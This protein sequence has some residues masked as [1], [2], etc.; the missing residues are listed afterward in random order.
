MVP[1][2]LL[3]FIA[4]KVISVRF[5]KPVGNMPLKAFSYNPTR[6]SE[7]SNPNSVGILPVNSFLETSNKVSVVRRPS[8]EGSVPVKLFCLMLKILIS[9]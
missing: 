8:S 3:L 1:S 4:S 6:R 2:R 5:D 7:V 9:F